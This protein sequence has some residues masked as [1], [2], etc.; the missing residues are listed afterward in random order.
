MF[1]SGETLTETYPAVPDSVAHA[2]TAL[3]AF[4]Q[5][6][7]ADQR[8]LESVRLATSEA[9]TNAVMHAYAQGQTGAVHVS[10]SYV[11]DEL[12]LLVADTGGGLRP[13][14]DS[15]GLGLGLALIAQLADEFQIVSR[16]SG[17]TEVR[18]RFTLRSSNHRSE[19][20]SPDSGQRRREPAGPPSGSA[21]VHRGS[22]STAFSAA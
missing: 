1:L 12:W 11:E 3:T 15:P 18:M 4:A 2:R 19:P 9:V 22:V 14:T 17:G 6:A 20:R 13:R 16:G 5:E 7:G 21:R 8:Q 10:A